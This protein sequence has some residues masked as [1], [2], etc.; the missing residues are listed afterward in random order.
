M[1]ALANYEYTS[2]GGRLDFADARGVGHLT[3]DGPRGGRRFQLN[4]YQDRPLMAEV[5]P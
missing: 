3:L 2:G 4:Y 1:E 5:R